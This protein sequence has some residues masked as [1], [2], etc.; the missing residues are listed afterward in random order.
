MRLKGRKKNC[1]WSLIEIIVGSAIVTLSIFGVLSVAKSS[2]EASERAL[3]T[4]QAGFILS[5]GAEAVRSMRDSLWQN[6]SL[7]ST[8]T[9]YRLSFST[10]TNKFATTTGVVSI[11][12]LFDRTFSVRDVA[13]DGNGNIA[14]SGAYDSGTK[15]IIM[16]V[17]WLS[18]AATTTKSVEFYISNI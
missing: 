6:I 17:S 9:V 5:E 2:L 8:T 15:K 11:D 14:S 13:R 16:N 18:R 4:A 7:L 10:S 12:G 1:G 3:R